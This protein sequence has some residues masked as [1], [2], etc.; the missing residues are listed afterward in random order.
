MNNTMYRNTKYVYYL[1]GTYY[2]NCNA[3]NAIFN[4]GIV[5]FSGPSIEKCMI[6]LGDNMGSIEEVTN[7]YGFECVFIIKIPEMFLYPKIT[8]GV[9][10]QVPVPMWEE[11]GGADIFKSSIIHGAY[12]AKDQEYFINE[13]YNEVYNPN[14]L[15][16]D[17]E[18][19]KYFCLMNMQR[20]IK[21]DKYR[22]KKDYNELLKIDRTKTIWKDA[23]TQYTSYYNRKCIVELNRKPVV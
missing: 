3:V 20:W 5:S 2:M 15:Q 9:L 11:K 12:S 4:E 10:N 21:F 23:I 19:V 1:Y 6:K 16:F 17:R 14:G 13:F 18:Q 8:D 7:N 22:R